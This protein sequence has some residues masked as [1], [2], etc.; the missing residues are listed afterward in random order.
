[1]TLAKSVCTSRDPHTLGSLWVASRSAVVSPPS[2]LH[3]LYCSSDLTHPSFLFSGRSP[4]STPRARTRTQTEGD[5]AHQTSGAGDASIE[6]VANAVAAAAVAAAV[7]SAPGMSVFSSTGGIGMDTGASSYP[8][9]AAA[10]GAAGALAAATATAA[11]AGGEPVKRQRG[12]FKL[13]D[14][15]EVS[16]AASTTASSSSS[17]GGAFAGLAAQQQPQSM[18]SSASSVVTTQ[19]DPSPG[20]GATGTAAAAA[21]MQ[22]TLLLLVEQN[23]QLLER[24]A[25]AAGNNGGSNGLDLSTSGGGGGGG[26][27]GVSGGGPPLTGTGPGGRVDPRVM[28]DRHRTSSMSALTLQ[29]P[30]PPKPPGAGGGASERRESPGREGTPA[31]WWGP[32][33]QQQGGQGQGQPPRRP[34]S[35]GLGRGE[36]GGGS[37][38]GSSQG[39]GVA[40]GSGTGLGNGGGGAVGGVARVKDDGTGRRAERG[41]LSTLLDQLRDEIDL[42]AAAKRDMDLELKRVRRSLVYAVQALSCRLGFLSLS[43]RR[44]DRMGS[45]LLRSSLGFAHALRCACLRVLLLCRARECKHARICNRES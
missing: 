2:C 16:A 22:A 14:I 30:L 8:S 45:W 38:G 33:G 40:G 1:M 24:I 42:T 37:G 19:P 43:R 39:G 4:L 34:T 11:A 35:A 10:A 23:R 25:A 6:A 32:Q 44:E 36:A 7:S 5:A 12:R 26:S 20:A 18:N 28:M 31:G 9:A 15:R 27:G 13:R 17:T 29:A 3:R 21:D 41:R